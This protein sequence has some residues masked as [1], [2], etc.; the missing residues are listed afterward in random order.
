MGADT[1]G[2]LSSK[3]NIESIKQMIE[4]IATDVE[5]NSTL[6][7][8]LFVINFFKNGNE[9]SLFVD[10]STMRNGE[11]YGIQGVRISLGCW[12]E[13]V[14]IIK[15]LCEAFGGYMD[16]NDSDD[17][18]FYPVNIELYEKNSSMTKEEAFKLKLTNI[19]GMN[20]LQK[21]LQLFEEY[22]NIS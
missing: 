2:I 19:V 10:C 6:V 12:G 15:S 22:K 21:V 8:G 18:G 4:S 16:E 11:I 5:M 9:R 14:Q 7:D 3:T 20:N 1:T 13:S 17:E